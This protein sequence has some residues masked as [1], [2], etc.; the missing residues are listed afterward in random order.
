MAMKMKVA[1]LK[2]ELKARG[3]S[4]VGS[5]NELLQQLQA[6]TEVSND[7]LTAVQWEET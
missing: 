5:K 2:Q 4:A 7:L 3:L 6:A 1:D